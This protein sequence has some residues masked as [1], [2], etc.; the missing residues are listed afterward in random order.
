MWDLWWTSWHWDRFS[1][2]YFGFALSISFHRCSITRQ[3][4]KTDHLSLHL[5]H[6][7]CTI[8][9]KAAVTSSPQKKQLLLFQQ[10]LSS[11]KT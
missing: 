9:L 2:E 8:S 5:H 6:K 7:C 11:L 1:S 10:S 4:E 3:N